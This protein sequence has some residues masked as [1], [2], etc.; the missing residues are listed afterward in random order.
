MYDY[1]ARMYDPT[2]GRMGQ[3][4]PHASRYSTVTPYNYTLNSPLNFT[5]PDGKDFRLIIKKDKEGNFN[6]TIQSTIH[7]Y[8]DKSSDDTAK[9]IESFYEKL[10]GER[11][12]GDGVTL[13]FDISVKHH[14]KKEDAIEATKA[15]AGD[16]LFEINSEISRKN[17]NLY[18][19]Q[20][21][22]KFPTGVRNPGFAVRG[23]REGK[24][25]NAI[26]TTHEIGHLL[27]LGDRY[28]TIEGG[29][30]KTDSGFSGDIMSNHYPTNFN[31]VHY[32]NLYHF[33]IGDI[34]Q[35]AKSG[36]TRT[37]PYM[38]FGGVPEPDRKPV[39]TIRPNGPIF[40]NNL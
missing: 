7:T 27:G 36:D 26:T 10:G 22:P 1:H 19:A 3:I 14:D 18:P 35:S 16:N 30:P 29:Y 25:T 4:D 32:K 33:I 24:A 17:L 12:V 23:G 34:D 15:N 38:D 5:D 20:E 21:D 39:S 28:S 2:I 37:I 6:I 13:N 31:S 8:G 40:N 9:F 11:N